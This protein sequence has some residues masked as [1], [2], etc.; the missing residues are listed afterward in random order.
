M[1]NGAVPGA[2]GTARLV[3]T[4]QVEAHIY[5]AVQPHSLDVWR[6]AGAVRCPVTVACGRV[7]D[8][9]HGGIPA[10]MPFVVEK[11]PLGGLER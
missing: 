10:V 6:G 1:S 9:I 11:L 4:P 3:C 7:S 2:D 8:G 5:M